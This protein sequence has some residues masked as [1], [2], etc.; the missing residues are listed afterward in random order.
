M[1]HIRDILILLSMMAVLPIGI[2]TANAVEPVTIESQSDHLVI[3]VHGV[4]FTIFHYGESVRK[5]YFWPVKAADGAIL[6]RPIDPNDK[7]H[8]HHKGI[9]LSVD[10][11]NDNRFWVERGKIETRE[12]QIVSGNPGLIKLRNEW[13]G[14]DGEPALVESTIISIY[15]NR[16]ITY[17]ILLNRPTNKL[18]RFDDTKEGFLGIRVAQSM[19]RRR[20]HEFRGQKNDERM[21]GTSSQLGGLFR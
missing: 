5:P 6:T 17:D 16:L 13:I 12:I 10:E 4:E 11:V 15:P 18:V 1:T 19:R 3:K 14:H 9:W 20:G 2:K 8:P 21:L 7:D